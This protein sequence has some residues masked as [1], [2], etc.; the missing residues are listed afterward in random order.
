VQREGLAGFGS[1]CVMQRLTAWIAGMAAET[2]VEIKAETRRF[3]VQAAL[4][5]QVVTG[6]T[7]RYFS[8]ADV[9]ERVL[10]M[11]GQRSGGWRGRES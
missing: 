5:V 4:G 9:V 3:E 2:L 1:F 6:D 8:E 7:E 10:V 11:K